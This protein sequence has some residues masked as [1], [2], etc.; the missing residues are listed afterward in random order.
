MVPSKVNLLIRSSVSVIF[1][2]SYSRC[3]IGIQYLNQNRQQQEVD[4]NT[5]VVGIEASIFSNERIFHSDHPTVEWNFDAFCTWFAHSLDS[6]L[7]KDINFLQF[8]ISDSQLFV[9]QSEN[10]HLF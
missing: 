3:A 10:L 2:I 7:E 6:L 1:V 5:I 9:F 4:K 8:L